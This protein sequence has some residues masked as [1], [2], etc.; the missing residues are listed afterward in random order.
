MP[1]EQQYK[2]PKIEKLIRTPKL[3]RKTGIL[4]KTSSP[5][6]TT[7][8]K[9][10]TGGEITPKNNMV[11]KTTKT[12][13]EITSATTVAPEENKKSED[14]KK[15]KVKT[16]LEDN[17]SLEDN[18]S[19]V[20]YDIQRILKKPRLSSICPP[21]ILE[22][23]EESSK[24]NNSDVHLPPPPPPPTPPAPTIR[25]IEQQTRSDVQLEP[26]KLPSKLNNSDVNIG[27]PAKKL[28]QLK[29]PRNQDNP[30]PKNKKKNQRIQS[31]QTNKINNYF[32]TNNKS[33]ESSDQNQVLVPKENETSGS[34]GLEV[35]LV[36]SNNESIPGNPNFKL[37]EPDLAQSNI[38]NQQLVSEMIGPNDST[39]ENPQKC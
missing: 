34:P 37:N 17:M 30:K 6:K 36:S 23:P 18:L 9:I 4:T 3:T 16:T 13:P 2:R 8:N 38:S 5:I 20:K 15:I 32:R 35:R 14:D 22:I 24:L 10:N 12:R 26:P 29:P 27:K 7:K 1:V 19:P 31:E 28:V 25:S 11:E 21:R 33:Q 39:S